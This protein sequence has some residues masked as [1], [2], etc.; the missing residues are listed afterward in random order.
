MAELLAKNI[1][2]DIQAD[3]KNLEKLEGI[4]KK[5]VNVVSALDIY[6]SA[7]P[8]AQEAARQVYDPKTG[9]FNKDVEPYLEESLKK[10]IGDLFK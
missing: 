1:D 3:E 6:N 5:I 8:T 2:D 10:E 9:Q 4:K 7:L